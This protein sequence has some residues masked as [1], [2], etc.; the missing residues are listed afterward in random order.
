M[1]KFD[2]FLNGLGMVVLVFIISY[3][4]VMKFGFLMLLV[5]VILGTFIFDKKEKH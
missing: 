5:I 1:D 2:K 4:P 3:P